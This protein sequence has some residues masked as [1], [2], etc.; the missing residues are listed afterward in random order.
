MNLINKVA[1][2][3]RTP[4]MPLNYSKWDQLEVSSSSLTLLSS[5]YHLPCSSLMT[6]ISR[7]IPTLTKNLSFGAVI[8]LLL[9]PCLEIEVP[10]SLYQVEAARHP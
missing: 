4:N 8:P 3:L 7:V 1:G 6:P 2:K 10:I 9:A 5:H